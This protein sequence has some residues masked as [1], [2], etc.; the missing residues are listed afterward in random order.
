MSFDAASDCFRQLLGPCPDTDP[1]PNPNPNPEP[2]P[3]QCDQYSL[4]NTADNN[5]PRN[6]TVISFLRAQRRIAKSSQ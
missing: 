6:T 2:Q 1:N 4:E 5:Q 3:Q